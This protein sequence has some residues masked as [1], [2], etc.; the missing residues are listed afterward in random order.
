[1]SLRRSRAAR[2]GKAPAEPRPVPLDHAVGEDG[3][4]PGMAIPEPETPA[5]ARAGGRDD[6]SDSDVALD[7]SRSYAAVAAGTPVARLG[8]SPAVA[9]GTPAA[10]PGAG[11][12]AVQDREL[13]LRLQELQLQMLQERQEMQQEL[14]SLRAMVATRQGNDAMSHG[15]TVESALARALAAKP[16][17]FDGSNNA[18]YFGRF[19]AVARAWLERIERD[20]RPLSD[21]ER[22]R[23]IIECLS[24][25]A[26]R[27]HAVAGVR[28]ESVF[29][30][31]GLMTWLE[32]REPR[33]RAITTQIVELFNDLQAIRGADG[34]VLVDVVE[35]GM[36]A[37]TCTDAEAADLAK[38]M[39][40]VFACAGDAAVL[41]R[42]STRVDEDAT[43]AD[44]ADVVRKWA[45]TQSLPP[46]AQ[47]TRTTRSRA[48]GGA[49][50][51]LAPT[52][53]M[54]T[55]QRTTERGARTIASTS[56]G[57]ARAAPAA[58]SVPGA[59]WIC[60]ETGHVKRD[61]PQRAP[62]RESIGSGSQ[63]Q[64]RPE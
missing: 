25:R 57:T 14:R 13:A 3:A 37:L 11:P 44:V 21:G 49:R 46:E 19:A 31:D 28:D 47:T 5:Q 38:L 26:A 17:A 27:D 15:W 20:V 16:V 54:P 56:T 30:F 64:Q 52:M 59:C 51:L 7:R 34:N 32:D 58:A 40:L 50:T 2:K 12:A 61:C 42:L 55:Q 18:P 39:A 48:P 62:M 22:A 63:Q 1:M 4:V 53:P 24:G 8:V 6:G 36:S 60:G 33:P 45:E 29:T 23:A 41:R 10:L 43:Y 35:D 9:A